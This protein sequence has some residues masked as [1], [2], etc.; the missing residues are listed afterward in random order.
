[1]FVKRHTPI[2]G[3]DNLK[4]QSASLCL[5]LYGVKG[6]SVD[7]DKEKLYCC[8]EFHHLECKMT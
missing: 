2:L 7:T 8:Q 1:M 5:L 6:H 4:I 3:N